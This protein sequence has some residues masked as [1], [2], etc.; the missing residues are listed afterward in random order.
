MWSLGKGIQLFAWP[1][2]MSLPYFSLAVL[3]AFC[4]HVVTT[5]HKI[6][7]DNR[8]FI[9]RNL[10]DIQLFLRFVVL[11]F[12]IILRV[13]RFLFCSMRVETDGRTDGRA[14]GRTCPVTRF[15]GL[16]FH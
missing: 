11:L 4:T 13:L 8:N 12:A 7:A 10:F 3:S 1:A 2:C 6:C 5:P 15:D 16:A 14:D 9:N